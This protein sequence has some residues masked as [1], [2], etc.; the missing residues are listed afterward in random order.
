MQ[1]L[2]HARAPRDHCALVSY[3]DGG[4]AGLL[5]AMCRRTRRYDGHP[6]AIAHWFS[7]RVVRADTLSDAYCH[8]RRRTWNALRMPR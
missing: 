8:V 5:P 6:T 2:D 4:R 1:N 7:T 3:W